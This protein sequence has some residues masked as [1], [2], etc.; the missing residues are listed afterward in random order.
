MGTPQSGILPL[1]GITAVCKVFKPGDGGE[2][3]I[4]VGL[5]TS[6]LG[7]GRNDG[8]SDWVDEADC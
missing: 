1:C 2:R 4:E 3:D 5:P 8:I 7:E 6:L